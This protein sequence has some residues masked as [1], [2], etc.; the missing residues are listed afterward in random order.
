MNGQ[1]NIIIDEKLER[2]N[3]KHAGEHL[4][5]LWNHDPI[6]GR[7]VI[8]TYVEEHNDI[9]FSNIQEE[10]WEWIDRHSQIC[11]YSLDLRKCEDRS[12]CRPDAFELLSLNNG[13]NNARTSFV[14]C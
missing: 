11:K 10:A 12:C 6:N 13:S 5:E 7:P 14:F 2:K 8:F 4:C 9:I 3:F 1:A